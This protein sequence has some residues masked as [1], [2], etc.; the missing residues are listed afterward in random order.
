MQEAYLVLSAE[1]RAKG[2]IRPVRRTYKHVGSRPQYPLRDL[3]AEETTRYSDVGY[4]KFEVYPASEL[5]STGR[6]WTQAQLTSGCG[7]ETT[8]GQELAE[9]YARDPHFYGATYCV[10]CRMH[11]PV[12][13]DGEFVWEDGSRV[14]T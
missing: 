5:P 3:T 11:R 1:E 8:M 2:F 6:F 14:G 9:T 12:G 4:V 10:H 13:P 7:G